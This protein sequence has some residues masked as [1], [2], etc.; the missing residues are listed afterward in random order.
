MSKKSLLAKTVLLFIIFSWISSYATKNQSETKATADSL[1]SINIPVYIEL[2][3]QQILQKPFT[4]LDQFYLLSPGTYGQKGQHYFT[5]GFRNQGPNLFIDGMQLDAES[6]FPLRAISDLRVYHDHRPIEFGFS[7]SSL[8]VIETLEADTSREFSIGFN[9]SHAFNLSAW[10]G[11]LAI[12]LPLTK[13]RKGAALLFAARF[14]NTNNPDPIWHKS[15]HLSDEQLETLANNPARVTDYGIDRASN[16]V[17]A[18]DFV[19]TTAPMNADRMVLA[20]YLKLTVPLGPGAQLKMGSF[21]SIEKGRKYLHQN[22][23]FNSQNNPLEYNYRFDGFVAFDKQF[24][25]GNNWQLEWKTHLQHSRLFFQSGDHSHWKDFFDYGHIGTFN[26]YHQNAYE[27]SGFVDSIGNYYYVPT[28]F[29]YFDTLVRFSPAQTNPIQATFNSIL[30]EEIPGIRNTTEMSLLG[31]L[32]NGNVNSTVYGLFNNHGNVHDLYTESLNK[33]TRLTTSIKAEYKAYTFNLGFEYNQEHNSYYS[34]EPSRLWNYMRGMTNNHVWDFD[35]ANPIPI[36]NNGV[37]DTV[38][39]NR[40]YQADLQTEFSKQLRQALGLDIDGL[41]I[42]SIDS[43][44]PINNRISYID[45]H[46]N[47]GELQTPENLFH[48][49][50]FSPTELSGMHA[51]MVNYSGYD[52]QGNRIAGKQ[53][54][55]N[56]VNDFSIAPS[57]AIYWSAYADASRVWGKL[58]AVIGLRVDVYNANRPVM[59]D[60]Y[61]GAETYTAGEIKQMAEPGFSIPANIGDDFVVYVNGFDSEMIIA[62]RDGHDWYSKDGSEIS[63]PLLSPVV[64]ESFPYLKEQVFD[65]R[66]QLRDNPGG[67]L[68]DYTPAINLLPQLMFNYRI[69]NRVLL[70]TQYNS[71]TINPVN[72][73]FRPDLI[74]FATGAFHGTYRPNSALRPSRF[75]KLQA[76]FKATLNH[77]FSGSLSYIVQTATNLPQTHFFF[78]AWPATYYST[79]NSDVK[80][81]SNGATAILHFHPAKPEGLNA[82]VDFT[83]LRAVND[84]HVFYEMSNFVMNAH[85]GYHF[86]HAANTSSRFLVKLLNGLSVNAYGQ[87]RNGAHYEHLVSP[88]NY[89]TRKKPVVKHFN[90]HVQKD[91]VVGKRML[92]E[93]GLTIENLFGFKNVYQVYET[94]GLADE[95]GFLSDPVQQ[96]FINS[97]NDPDA[98]RL[99]YKQHLIKPEHFGSPRII[100]LGLALRL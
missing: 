13:K 41:E 70:Y 45:A 5:N 33:K 87:Y 24:N 55:Y 91:I 27:Y 64:I 26:T 50:L 92:L 80:Y 76:G 4:R 8:M 31:G 18:S 71:H 90:L 43:Y 62:Y 11:E 79:V 21:A 25:L 3:G 1:P 39:F 30:M 86:G 100:R 37:V 63:N 99:L 22:S 56:Y 42:I 51:K 83:L 2:D 73:T 28:L 98:Y 94:T 32:T 46:G 95:D 54:P 68:K 82:R 97:Q 48:L 38:M 59:R 96:K 49:G 81:T 93:A 84:H 36:Y 69:S 53:D 61:L 20:P 66:A 40:L 34:I 85:L 6:Y 74:Y 60:P 75:D 35:Y 67:I 78:R 23:V 88:F 7:G 57:E 44:D 16:Y 15:S 17:T 12:S 29:S 10:D 14:I 52:H 47:P 65:S 89:S 77:N 72:N 9:N 19:S 58:T